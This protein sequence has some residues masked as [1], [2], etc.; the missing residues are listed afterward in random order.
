MVS[1]K[2]RLDVLA[3][4]DDAVEVGDCVPRARK[5]RKRESFTPQ[6]DQ[7]IMLAFVTL[8]GRG[9][10]DWK[11]VAALV[12]SRATNISQKSRPDLADIYRRRCVPGHHP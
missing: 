3:D 5:R 10:V 4:A 12:S 7:V 9:K 2:K 11:K 6:E 1:R 8:S